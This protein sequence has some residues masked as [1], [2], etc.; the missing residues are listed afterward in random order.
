MIVRSTLMSRMAHGSTAHGSLSRMAK[1]AS[2]PGSMEPLID[3]SNDAYAALMVK[4]RMP[5]SGVSRSSGP[6]TLPARVVR[7]TAH[8]MPK[9]GSAPNIGSPMAAMGASEWPTVTTPARIA[10]FIGFMRTARSSP[11]KVEMWRSAQYHE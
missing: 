1:S 10:D 2:L 7:F 9:S 4:A 6:I 8:Q 11:M 3:S 5:S